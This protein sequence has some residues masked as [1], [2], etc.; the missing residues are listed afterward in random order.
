MGSL[1]RVTGS[2]GGYTLTQHSCLHSWEGTD[3]LRIPNECYH[4]AAALPWLF[5]F[6]PLLCRSTQP[7]SPIILQSPVVEVSNRILVKAAFRPPHLCCPSDSLSQEA[8]RLGVS[9]CAAD[10]RNKSEEQERRKRI[11][12]R[13][14]FP[15]DTACLRGQEAEETIQ[16]SFQRW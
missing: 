8:P 7:P 16:P 14:G 3:R 11:R 6:G 10:R 15:D 4:S 13:D 1:W 5:I 9:S 2:E 12:R